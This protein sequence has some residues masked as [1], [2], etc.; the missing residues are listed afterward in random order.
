MNNKPIPQ[1]LRAF[2]AEQAERFR[3]QTAAGYYDLDKGEEWWR[4]RYYLLEDHG[5][6]LRTRLRPGWT[7]S[8][9]GTDVNPAYCEDSLANC[10][11]YH[12]KFQ[13]FRVTFSKTRK[14]VDA[15]R[16]SDGREV[17]IMNLPRQSREREILRHLEGAQLATGKD[18]HIAPLLDSFEDDREPHLEFFVMPLMRRYYLLPF[19]AV[20]EVLDLF[21]Q[22]LEVCTALS[23]PWVFE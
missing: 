7:P 4:D 3:A 16:K 11:S 13:V 22:L 2:N 8:C 17:A 1:Y 10:V 23:S 14:V 21:R 19:E 6:Q 12:S 18:E 15:V 5:Y 20:S 9:Q